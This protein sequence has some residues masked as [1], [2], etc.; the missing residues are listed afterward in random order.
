MSR[1]K[2]LFVAGFSSSA[3]PFCISILPAY[4][5][6][7]L[8]RYLQLCRSESA[9]VFIVMTCFECRFVLKLLKIDKL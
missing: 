6:L 5:S 4:V 7:S 1:G 8:V 9:V 3:I 2:S